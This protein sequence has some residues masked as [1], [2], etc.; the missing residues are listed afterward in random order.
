[1]QMNGMAELI[2]IKR[3]WQERSDPRL[4]VAILHNNDLKQVTGE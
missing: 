2:T 4:M 3:Y 1:M